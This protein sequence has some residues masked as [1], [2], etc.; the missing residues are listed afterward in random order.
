M[1]SSASPDAMWIFLLVLSQA[2]TPTVDVDALILPDPGWVE[3]PGGG[4]QGTAA[5]P[6]GRGQPTTIGIPHN[7]S[8]HGR[9]GGL[10]RA[11]R[12]RQAHHTR[13]RPGSTARRPP[14]CP[15]R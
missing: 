8:P 5:G 9:G 15:A 14:S 4:E 6:L 12:G 13:D 3:A 11:E 7:R 2:A 10:P 1:T